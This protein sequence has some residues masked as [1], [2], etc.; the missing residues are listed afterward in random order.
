LKNPT[1]NTLFYDHYLETEGLIF[2]YTLKLKGNYYIEDIHQLRVNMKKL[3]AY[4]HFLESATNKTFRYKESNKLLKKSFKLA[5]YIRERQINLELLKNYELSDAVYLQYERFANLNDK[6]EKEKLDKAIDALN[7][8]E[9][10][11]IKQNFHD[12]FINKN[13][14]DKI[15]LSLDFIGFQIGKI[16][17]ILTNREELDKIHRIRIHLKTIKP[18]LFILSGIPESQFEEAHYLSLKNTEDAIGAWHDRIVLADSLNQFLSDNQLK[19]NRTEFEK[20]KNIL[21]HESKELLEQIRKTL[22]ETGEV[23]LWEGNSKNELHTT[24]T[25]DLPVSSHPS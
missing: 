14:H 7:I 15:E 21:D 6:K 3:R 22:L 1:A 8:E 16:K 19:Q 23:Y 18:I 12:F 24:P 13:L 4:F 17:T 25:P 20:V 9:F 5:G 10:E 2:Q 11:K